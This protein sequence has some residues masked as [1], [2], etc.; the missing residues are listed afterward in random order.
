MSNYRNSLLINGYVDFTKDDLTESLA[1]LKSGKSYNDSILNN[2]DYLIESARFQD[3]QQVPISYSNTISDASFE[4]VSTDPFS[5]E[6]WDASHV[7]ISVTTSAGMLTVYFNATAL[8]GDLSVI[9]FQ[10]F[11]DNADNS[12]NI[13]FIA[14]TPEAPGLLLQVITPVVATRINLA[15]NFKL[16]DVMNFKRSRDVINQQKKFETF[17]FLNLKRKLNKGLINKNKFVL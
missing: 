10:Q 14:D 11:I 17:E 2:F 13:L 15:R 6:T 4:Y 12:A 3:N 16:T 5:P 9:T 1:V 8:G 7:S